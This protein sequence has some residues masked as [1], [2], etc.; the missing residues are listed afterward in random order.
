MGSWIPIL[1]L[2]HMNITVILCTYGLSKPFIR[3]CVIYCNIYNILYFDVWEVFQILMIPYCLDTSPCLYNPGCFDATKT[4]GISTQAFV[5]FAA[6]YCASVWCWSSH[7][8]KLNTILNN[9]QRT[10]SD[11]CQHLSTNSPAWSRS[12]D[13]VSKNH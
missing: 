9:T 11:P 3:K 13:T 2:L 4:S 6:E 1:T 12:P 7:I 8:K 5:F 10:I